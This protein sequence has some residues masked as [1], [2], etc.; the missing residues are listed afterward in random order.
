MCVKYDKIDYVKMCTH[1]LHEII[2][3]NN[4]MLFRFFGY[5]P[6]NTQ[7]DR[8]TIGLSLSAFL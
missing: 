1:I 6:L 7:T 8:R 4:Q 5:L 3:R 2:R